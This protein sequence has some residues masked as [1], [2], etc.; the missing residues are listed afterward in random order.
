M[1]RSK[2]LI[3]LEE[4]WI[5]RHGSAWRDTAVS[6]EDLMDAIVFFEITNQGVR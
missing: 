2:F 6:V 1:T 3:E 4:F 5:N